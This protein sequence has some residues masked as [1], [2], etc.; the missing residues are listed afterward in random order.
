MKLSKSCD[1]LITPVSPTTAFRIGEKTEDPLT[2]YLSDMF[3]IP[4]S[5]AGLP[6]LSLPADLMIIVCPLGY[7]SLGGH[8]TKHS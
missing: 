3:T 5:L 8:W 4:S 1:I 6:A 7:R 2:M